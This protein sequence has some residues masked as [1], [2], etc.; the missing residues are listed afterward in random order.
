MREV[1]TLMEFLMTYGWA[2]LMI[3][4][5]LFALVYFN[6]LTPDRFD[7]DYKDGCEDRCAGMETIAI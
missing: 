1:S 7:P 4:T 5:C 3:G 6:V 2:I